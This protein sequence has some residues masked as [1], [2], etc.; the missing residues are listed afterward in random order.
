M[1]W[2]IFYDAIFDRE[3]ER[4]EKISNRMGSEKVYVDT[5][6]SQAKQFLLDIYNTFDFT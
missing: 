5:G 3:L 6:K 1:G 2:K 4:L